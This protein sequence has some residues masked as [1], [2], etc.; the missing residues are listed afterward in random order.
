MKK[1]PF[2]KEESLIAERVTRNQLKEFLS[3]RGFQRIKD[4]RGNNSQQIRAI[5][6]SG[7]KINMRVK[8]C[9]RRESGSRDAARVKTYSAAQILS[10]IKD[11][12]WEGSLQAKVDREIEKE[13][14]HFLFVQG[15]DERI[16]FAGL[17]P[18]MELIPIWC[19]QR[20][21][22]EELINTGRSGRITKNTA[23]NGQSPSIWLQDERVPEVADVFWQYPGVEDLAKLPVRHIVELSDFDAI[24]I[25]MDEKKGLVHLQKIVETL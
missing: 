10:Q 13:T 24:D 3:E 1:R 9:W 17:V 2:R 21:V 23:M 19:K 14:T 16:L 6:P 22:A 8:L 12:D 5:T 4:L 15:E 20:D 25:K 18:I 7:K 11:E